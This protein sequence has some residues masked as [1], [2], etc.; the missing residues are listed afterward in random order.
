LVVR[1]LI[2]NAVKF[3]PNGGFIHIDA[4]LVLHECKITVT[5]NGKGIPINK[6]KN[7]FSIISEPEFGTNNEKGV[8]LGLVLCKEYIARQGGRIG[9]ES[10]FEKGSSF[11]IF[12]P[13]KS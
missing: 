2:S 1:N 10:N 12:V 13:S 9:F 8:G 11:F 6:Q 4:Q 3:T 5:D 7:I